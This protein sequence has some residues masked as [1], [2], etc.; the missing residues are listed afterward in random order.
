MGKNFLLVIGDREPLAWILTQERMAF[1]A[2]R[3]RQAAELSVGDTLFMYTTRGCFHYPHRH[4]GHVIGE[5]TV[6]S[7][8]AALD[9]PVQFD[10]K[11]FPLG[12]DL[13]I[14]GVVERGQGPVL[15]DLVDELHLFPTSRGWMTRLRN[16]LV[17]L[18][19]H[20]AQFL[21]RELI[22]KML[23]VAR[24]RSRYIERTSLAEKQPEPDLPNAD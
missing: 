24:V 7:T 6:K 19:I 23:P 2:H 18:D 21:H 8:V 14:A 12:C 1:P 9:N 22:Q 17:P 15:A 16:V 3:A 10:A 20:D 4:M 11:D 13:Q 5:A